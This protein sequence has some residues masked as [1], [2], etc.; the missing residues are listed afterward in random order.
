L[1]SRLCYSAACKTA[2]ANRRGRHDI[3]SHLFTNMRMMQVGNKMLL[4]RK[5]TETSGAATNRCR[6]SFSS[7][8]FFILPR[9]DRRW[10]R[11]LIIKYSFYLD[12]TIDTI[13]PVFRLAIFLQTTQ[14]CCV[15]LL[16]ILHETRIHLKT[17]LHRHRVQDQTRTLQCKLCSQHHKK[18]LFHVTI[19]HATKG[20]EKSHLISSSRL[21]F[22]QEERLYTNEPSGTVRNSD[23]I[24]Q[25]ELIVSS[26]S[27]L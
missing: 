26:P 24:F 13:S 18:Q 7:L 8:F 3:H 10:Q 15:F 5:E 21:R 27:S 4:Q 9:L 11:C 25:S 14:R 17:T 16:W 1:S 2:L 23:I 12:Q 19:L 6:Q 22:Y 20:M